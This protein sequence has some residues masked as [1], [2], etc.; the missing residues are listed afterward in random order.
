MEINVYLTNLAKYNAGRLFGKWIQL[1][2]SD[3]ELQKAFQEVLGNDEEYFLTDYEAPFSI[4]EYDNLR[5]LNEFSKHLEELSDF[6]QEKVIF[7]I[8]ELG[9]SRSESLKYYEDVI[10]YENMTLRDVAYDLVDEGVFGDIADSIK[11]YIDYESIARDLSI[12]GYHENDKGVF[13]YV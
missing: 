2:L 12:D 3:D 9:Y 8:E 6:D 4:E 7:L 11:C 5:E 1:P 10:F 13:Y